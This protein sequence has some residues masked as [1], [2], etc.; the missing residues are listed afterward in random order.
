MYI[1][2]PHQKKALEY[3]HHISLSANAGSGKTFVLTKRYLQIV[4]KEEISLREVAA[5]TFTE[6]AASELYKKITS[7]VEKILN[8]NLTQKKYEKWNRIR[9]ELVS[10][11]I[12]TIH[13]FCVDIL[14][15]FPVEANIDANFTPIDTINSDELIELSIEDEIK[16]SFNDKVKSDDIKR[17]IRIVGSKFNLSN[18]LTD[19]VKDRRKLPFINDLFSINIDETI[20]NYSKKYIEYLEKIFANDILKIKDKIEFINELVLSKKNDNTFGVEIKN[21]LSKINSDRS[22]K[23]NLITFKDIGGHLLTGSYE[24]KKRG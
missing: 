7:E 12:S 6:K 1:L 21:L 19:I 10:A 17:I 4:E 14:K 22:T 16:K 3:K 23:E 2:T 9:R 11:H 13:S 20:S 15:Q 24:V 8:S 18:I 5:I